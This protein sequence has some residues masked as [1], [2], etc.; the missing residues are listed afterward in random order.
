MTRTIFRNARIFTADAPAGA[1]A[2]DTDSAAVTWAEALVVD[3]DTLAHVGDEAGAVRIAGADAAIV[4]LGGRLV[5]P[6]FTDAHTHLVMMGDALGR[7]GLT[8]A[9]TLDEIRARLRAARAADPDAPR[10]L[11]RGWL[12][13]SVPGGAPTAAMLDAAVTDVPVY[14]DANDYHSC[15]VNSAALAELGITRDTPDPI[16]GRISRDADGE[17]DGMLYETAAQQFAW[18]HLANATTDAD[19]DA[20]VERTIDAYLAT[21]VTGVVDMAFDGLGLAA[22]RRAAERRGGSLPIRVA[23]HWFVANTGDDAANLAQVAEAARLAAETSAAPTAPWLRIVGIKL[24]LDGVIDACTAAM[25]HP[26]ADGSNAEPIWPPAALNPVVAAADAAG[27]QVAQHAIGDYA[28]EIAL[29][30][31]EHAAEVN[32]DRPRRHRIEHLEYAAPGTAERMSRLGVTASMQPVHADPAIFDNWVAMLGDERVERAF[33]WPEYVD[34]G[35]LLAFS[36]DAPTAPHEALH[37]MY[38]AATRKSALDPSHAPALPGFALP[39]A[40]AIGHATRDAA[41]SCGD[42]DARGRLVAGLAADFA[43]LDVDPFEVGDEALLTARVIRTVVAGATV[44]EAD[45]DDGAATAAR[46]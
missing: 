44:F 2:T 36:T 30:A 33:A 26:Y 9:R 15:W 42:G 22:F 16:G 1:A 29:D 13:D 46:S 5:L 3:G 8:D 25:R 6:G 31:L 18:D 17:A 40:Q 37:N 12:F 24:V 41:A 7:V 28:S 11:G 39:L 21:G 34:A 45:A 10:V 27:L 20:A 19:R 14:L 32:G 4:D 23:A 35:A 38:V 43:V